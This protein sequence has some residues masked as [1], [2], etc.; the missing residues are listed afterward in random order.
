MISYKTNKKHM[1]DSGYTKM[2]QHI[3]YFF[4]QDVLDHP[5]ALSLFYLAYELDSIHWSLVPYRGVTRNPSLVDAL[6]VISEEIYTEC[7]DVHTSDLFREYMGRVVTPRGVAAR[8]DL[9]QALTRA[10]LILCICEKYKDLLDY[11]KVSKALQRNESLKGEYTLEAEA[12]MALLMICSYLKNGGL[13]IYD[14]DGEVTFKYGDVNRYMVHDALVRELNAK[15]SGKSWF[16]KKSKNMFRDV[17]K[18]YKRAK[19][20]VTLFGYLELDE[21]E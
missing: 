8:Y 6:H 18:S 13:P 9:A 21:E 19:N 10:S 5:T 12:T 11:E 2:A 17:C 15:K 3:T 14:G 20:E 7:R 16:R 1:I 4:E